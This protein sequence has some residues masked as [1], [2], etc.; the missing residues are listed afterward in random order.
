M[1]AIVATG[2]LLRSSPPPSR[3]GALVQSGDAAGFNI[4]LVT[5]DT[6]RP[7]RLG[8]YGYT[9]GQ[10]PVIDSLVQHGVLFED[11][12]TSVPLTLPSHTTILTGLYPP[13][14]GIR[15][16][17]T[18]RLDDSFVTLPETLKE[19]GYDTAAFI[20]CFV[21]DERFGLNQGFDVYNFE[22]TP[23]GNQPSNANF[24]DRPAAAVTDAAIDWLERR[25][26]SSA[27]SPFFCW[28]HYFDPHTPYRSPLQRIPKFAN[29]PYDAE[30]AYV[31]A[32]FGRLLSHLDNKG[33]RDRTLIV[34][35][36]D[37][38][39]AFGEHN[40]PTHGMLIYESTMRA[41]FILSC[42]GLF[43]GS[44]RIGDKLTGLI[45]VRATIEDLVGLSPL[46]P[47][48]GQSLLRSDRGEG[49]PIYIETQ[50]PLY[51]NGWS[52]LYGLR[53]HATKFILAPE[54]E[55]YD[56]RTDAGERRNLYPSRPAGLD[57]SEQLLDELLNDEIGADVAARAARKITAEEV[58]RL[59]SL[60]YMH[61][62][63]VST[64][65]DLPDPKVMMPLYNKSIRAASLH[66]LGR[67][68]EAA[69]LAREVLD[70]C[71]SCMLAFGTLAFSYA[72]LGRGEEAVDVLRSALGRNPDVFRI[73][74]LALLLIK[75]KQYEQA[76]DVLRIYQGMD[77]TDGRVQLYRGNALAN[78]GRFDEAITMYEQAIRIDEN[79]VGLTARGRIERI[80]RLQAA[81]QGSP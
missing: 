69:V 41:A 19:N 26:V 16:N 64:T 62:G 60:G 66:A 17:G 22:V 30:I 21:L 54:P 27:E 43:D 23:E 11:A 14:H 1:A 81:D 29:R 3:L 20:G 61:T 38:G 18:F 48:D 73:S 52:P 2:E 70:E 45:D 37:H 58:D 33:I 24:N 4:L 72:E 9:R 13:H 80:R 35:V 56:L 76:E 10:T 47:G 28:V 57:R 6:L 63:G 67:H 25:S 79:R 46:S 55:F 68:A 71:E 36:S 15:N 59:R 53:T 8:C 42:P 39:E 5:L 49:D 75:L 50:E 77:P 34:L 32:E 51:V 12:V 78:Q 44:H 40:E 7:D 31:D 65:Q 74:S